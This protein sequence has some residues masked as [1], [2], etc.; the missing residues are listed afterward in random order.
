VK[1]LLSRS[2]PIAVMTSALAT[3]WR[4]AKE[5]KSGKARWPR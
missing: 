1:K 4:S 2:P 3:S 5:L